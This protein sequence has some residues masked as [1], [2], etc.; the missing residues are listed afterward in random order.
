MIV[1]GSKFVLK[2]KGLE[3]YGET[4]VPLRAKDLTVILA[5]P[6][7]STMDTIRHEAEFLARCGYKV[8]IFDF[9]G[10]SV[11]SK[12]G[13]VY[14]NSLLTEVRDLKLIIEFVKRYVGRNIVLI[15]YSQGGTVAALTAATEKDLKGVVLFYPA[16]NIPDVARLSFDKIGDIPEKTTVLGC[17][18]GRRYYEDV[19]NMNIFKCLQS[20]HKTLI[21]HGQY[22]R[23]VPVAYSKFAKKVLPNSALIRYKTGHA[24]YM[25]N[26]NIGRRVVTFLE[27]LL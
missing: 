24:F 25:A 9:A 12:S 21:L 15:G 11:S 14:D 23:I 6:F 13:S 16:L 22:D 4:L 20:H 7:G 18:V 8:V 26:N 17:P 1:R 2:A 3:L 10:G 5:H 19:Y 27:N